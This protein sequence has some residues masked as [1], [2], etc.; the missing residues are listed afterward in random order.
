MLT[1][2]AFA[3]GKWCPFVRLMV[4]DQD[5]PDQ[6]LGPFN[7]TEDVN[8]PLDDGTKTAKR[9]CC[10]GSDCMAWRWGN[11]KSTLGYCGLAGRAA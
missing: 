2:E 5:N 9:Y 6:P 4:V 8:D 11:D 3:R 1:L 7:R 10:I